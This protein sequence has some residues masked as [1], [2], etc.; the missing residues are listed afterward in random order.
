[1]TIENELN[2]LKINVQTLQKEIEQLKEIVEGF[3]ERRKE[4]YYQ[5]YLEKLFSATHKKTKHGITDITTNTA[6]IEIKHWKNYKNAL[7]QLLS[8][9]QSDPTKLLHAY[10]FGMCTDSLKNSVVELFKQNNISVYELIDTDSGIQIN[11]VYYHL[12]LPSQSSFIN[13]L[14]ENVEEKEGG[15]LKL[16]EVCKLYTK[17]KVNTHLL[18]KYR[19]EVEKWIKSKFL[20]VKSEY[21]VVKINELS[22]K[23]W[24]G[25]TL[26]FKPL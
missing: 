18:G 25:I 12:N 2:L 5:R 26:K 10:F 4:Q 7:G 13:W 15:L 20:Y 11:Q 14:E 22:Y 9:K 8:Y 3:T 16:S 17:N 1:M 19:K 23:G 21:G 24:K 6:I